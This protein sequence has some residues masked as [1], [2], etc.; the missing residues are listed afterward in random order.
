MAVCW[1]GGRV[2]K[3][4]QGKDVSEGIQAAKPGN[5]G[6]GSGEPGGSGMVGQADGGGSSFGQVL[7]DVPVGNARAEALEGCFRVF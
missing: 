4:F 3:P 6:R 5:P 1:S 7:L 2:I